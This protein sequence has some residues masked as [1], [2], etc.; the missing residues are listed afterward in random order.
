MG[1]VS[2]GVALVAL[3]VLNAVFLLMANAAMVTVPLTLRH[4]RWDVIAVATAAMT[5]GAVSAFHGKPRLWQVL[6]VAFLTAGVLAVVALLFHKLVPHHPTSQFFYVV[7]HV[8][9]GGAAFALLVMGV[10]LLMAI[11]YGEGAA[12]R[13][14]LGNHTFPRRVLGGR[15]NGAKS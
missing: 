4:A 15:R 11:G 10:G 14:I 6:S 9:E 5:I 12:V 1:M 8:W 2:T 13:R 3:A 7:E